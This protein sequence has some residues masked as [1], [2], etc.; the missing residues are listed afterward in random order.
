MWEWGT[1]RS[2]VETE[3]LEELSLPTPRFATARSEPEVDADQSQLTNTRGSRVNGLTSISF[4]R[5][6]SASNSQDYAMSEADNYLIFA[7]GDVHDNQFPLYHFSNK[8]VS[9]EFVSFACSGECA[10]ALV[11]CEDEL[12]LFQSIWTFS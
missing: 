6:C 4:S 2:T 5:H 12:T 8:W 3:S 9:D 10:V 11:L 1:C 7:I